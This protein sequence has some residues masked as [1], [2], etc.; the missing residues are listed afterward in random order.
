MDVAGV[1]WLSR[2]EHPSNFSAAFRHWIAA[3]LSASMALVA[4]FLVSRRLA[5]GL[6][7]PLPPLLLIGLGL[8]AAASAW[9]VHMLSLPVAPAHDISSFST[10]APRLTIFALPIIAIAVSLPG[11]STFG[12]IVLWLTTAGAEIGLWRLRKGRRT[13]TARL[14]RDGGRSTASRSTDEQ[15]AT[16]DGNLKPALQ[17]RQA[18]TATQKLVYHRSIDGKV[19]V[20][21][22][23]QARFIADERTAII[24]V[25][26]CP[27][28]ERAPH[29]EGELVDGPPG[30]VRPT[31]VLPWG[32]RW[33]VKLDSPA[34]APTA[35]AIEFIAQEFR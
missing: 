35:A 2:A 12:L 21:G 9:A 5:G 4:I 14:I 1:S 33:E 22:W 23:M 16:L 26:F 15:A 7:A 27:A 28:F 19:R 17:H 25:A 13:Q 34:T 30:E 6:T 24:H 10:V 20:E 8:I 31:L 3:T 32:V 11:S 29:V 18:E